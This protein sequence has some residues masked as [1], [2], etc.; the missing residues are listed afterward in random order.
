[1]RDCLSSSLLWIQ[2]SKNRLIRVTIVPD[3]GG[4]L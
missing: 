3:V 1:V 4:E 2:H